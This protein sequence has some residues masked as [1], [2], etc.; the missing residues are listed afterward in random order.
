MIKFRNV[1]FR[2]ASSKPFVLDNVSMDL[3]P[4]HIYG[5]LRKNGVGKSTMFRLIS[6]LNP[7]TQGSV[8]TLQSVP[9]KRSPLMLQDIFLLPEEID[10]PAMTALKY[11]SLYGAFYPKFSLEKMKTYLEQ[12]NIRLD[13]KL[14]TM[15]Q[16]QRKKAYI[17][18]AL[19][20]NTRI[21]LMD[22]PTNGL[23]IP[24]KTIFRK[25]L[26]TCQGEERLIIISTHQ[27]RDLER[28]IDAVIIMEEQHLALCDTAENLLKTFHFGAYEPDAEVIYHDDTERGRIGLTLRGDAPVQTLDDLD[29][30]I[31]FNAMV[32]DG[33]QVLEHLQMCSN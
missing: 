20:C 3:Q 27:V 15:S 14:N 33:E 29:L 26:A 23:D 22:E 32:M 19:A 8:L 7:V 4:G 10:F 1:S 25:M 13:Q 6:G 18:F 30:E 12:F 31:L 17:A 2:Y 24:S 11:G 5:L 16:G 21:L 28:L 9:F